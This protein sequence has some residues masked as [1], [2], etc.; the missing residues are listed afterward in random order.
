MTQADR[1]RQFVRDRY[2]AP[3]RI[4]GRAQITI[5]AGDVHRAMG[6]V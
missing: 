2:V 4:D 1:I 3:A 6:L 5:R